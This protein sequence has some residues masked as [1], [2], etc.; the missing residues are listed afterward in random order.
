[1]NNV[2][3]TVGIF[4]KEFTFARLKSAHIVLYC[5]KGF[6]EALDI[7]LNKYLNIDE[8]GPEILRC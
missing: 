1:M 4:T 6:K 7:F 3:K 5:R 2:L 8:N